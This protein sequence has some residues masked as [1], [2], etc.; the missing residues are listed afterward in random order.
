[1]G[2]PEQFQGIF[3]DNDNQIKRKEP[4]LSAEFILFNDKYTFTEHLSDADELMTLNEL[5]DLIAMQG[6]VIQGELIKRGFKSEL[7]GSS[8]LF[9]LKNK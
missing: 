5:V 7:V 1:M 8:N 3:M 4:V 6:H 9:L 2:A